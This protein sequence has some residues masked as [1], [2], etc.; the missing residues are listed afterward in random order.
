MLWH[1]LGEYHFL[2]A[3]ADSDWYRTMF[4]DSKTYKPPASD[5]SKGNSWE[6]SLLTVGDIDSVSP[7]ACQSADGSRSRTLPGISIIY[8]FQV[9]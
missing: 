5:T 4:F 6:A 1:T 3:K 2:R 7:L 9:D 8:D